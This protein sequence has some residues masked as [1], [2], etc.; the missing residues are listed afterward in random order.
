MPKKTNTAKKT[1]AK[2]AVTKKAAAAKKVVKKAVTKKVAA[3]KKVPVKKAVTK[4]ATNK[5][6]APKTAKKTTKKATNKTAPAKKVTPK[7]VQLTRIT[8]RVDVGFGNQLYI[9]G[10]GGGL[11]WEQGI[12]MENISPYEWQFT[13]HFPSKQI[14]FKFLI[15]DELWAEGGSLSVATGKSSISSP[16][17]VW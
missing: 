7:A 2:K 11:D 12:I 13:T 4:K 6:A 9:R 3:A 8:A 16:N 14:E 1:P 15:N 5:K 10:E 17:F